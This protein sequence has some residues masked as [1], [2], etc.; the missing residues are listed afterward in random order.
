[1]L[2]I[3][4]RSEKLPNPATGELSVPMFPAWRQLHMKMDDDVKWHRIAW[5]VLE[6][7]PSIRFL[8]WF[9][10]EQ[11]GEIVDWVNGQLGCEAG[12]SMPPH[13]DLLPQEVREEVYDDDDDDD[14]DYSDSD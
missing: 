4:E 8:R 7:A 6:P 3:K 5:I 10:D 9:S 2:R 1:M 12:A 14:G 11:K 13:P